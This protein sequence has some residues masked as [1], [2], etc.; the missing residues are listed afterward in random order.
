M[1]VYKSLLSIGIFYDENKLL[2]TSWT[3]ES[4]GMDIVEAKNEFLEILKIVSN[5]TPKFILAD[6]CK[7][8]LEVDQDFQNW[9]V[10]K[11]IAKI[12]DLKVLKYAILVSPEAFKDVSKEFMADFP[13]DEFEVQYF[14]NRDQALN[15]MGIK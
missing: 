2:E 9:I 7:F 3:D 8:K 13:E 12:I 5:Y 11:F 1:I 10:L 15:W 4:S 14:T 6:T